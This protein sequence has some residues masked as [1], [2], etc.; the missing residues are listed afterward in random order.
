MA[1][2]GL[3]IAQPG[4]D[5]STATNQQLVLS[6]SFNTLKNYL[7]GAVSVNI[8]ANVS[9]DITFSGTF[10]HALGFVP[11][12]MVFP[13][14]GTYACMVSWTQQ[15]NGTPL[16]NI[17]LCNYQYTIDSSNLIFYATTASGSSFPGNSAF[18]I[19]FKYYIFTQ[20]IG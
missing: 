18:T 19:N 7:I 15:Q 9:D 14:D 11:A 1:D 16:S 20:Q 10:N 8:P 6:S 2:Y 13:N 5:V 12:V 4:F 17:E 3:K